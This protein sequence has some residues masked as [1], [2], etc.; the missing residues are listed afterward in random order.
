MPSILKNDLE[1]NTGMKSAFLLLNIFM[2][3]IAKYKIYSLLGIFVLMIPNVDEYTCI[4]RI[5]ETNV[6]GGVYIS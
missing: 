2:H 4:T 1:T 5:Y 3:L 6:F